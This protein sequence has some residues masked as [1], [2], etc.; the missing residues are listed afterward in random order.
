MPVLLLEVLCILPFQVKKQTPI[1]DGLGTQIRTLL[2]NIDD[3]VI[4]ESCQNELNLPVTAM[5][6]SSFN[7][8]GFIGF[9]IERVDC[10]PPKARSYDVFYS[11]VNHAKII[12][13]F[14]F[15][16]KTIFTIEAKVSCHMN[17]YLCKIGVDTPI[18]I[19]ICISQSTS[20]LTINNMNNFMLLCHLR[21]KAP[22]GC[23][24]TNPSL[25]AGVNDGLSPVFSRGRV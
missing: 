16:L 8:E 24:P 1:I 4:F 18:S 21:A 10:S 19:L 25:K 15:S 17:Q 6:Q 3:I 9:K 12:P 20:G 5:F 22:V 23:V 7:D 13:Y 11:I 2:Y 14:L